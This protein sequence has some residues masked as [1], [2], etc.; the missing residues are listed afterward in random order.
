[1]QVQKAP[2]YLWV[3][4]VV[5]TLR[6]NPLPDEFITHGVGRGPV[7]VVGGGHVAVLHDGVVEVAVEGRFHRGYVFQLG[8]ISHGNLLLAVARAL[9]SSSHCDL[10]L[11]KSFQVPKTS[12]FDGEPGASFASVF[13]ATGS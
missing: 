5:V 12:R 13:L 7:E 9:G 10:Q 1:M 11:E 3:F 2:G 8:D 4:R 6:A